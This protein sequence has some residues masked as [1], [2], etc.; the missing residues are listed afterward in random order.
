MNY[1]QAIEDAAFASG[2][3]IIGTR[4][5][6]Q[7][8]VGRDGHKSVER[9]VVLGDTCQQHLCK[10]DRRKFTIRK[11]GRQLGQRLQMQRHQSRTLGTRYSPSE[12]AAAFSW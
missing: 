3:R 8:C 10:L 9:V 5:G 11:T 6:S 7:G 1:G 4:G 12:T 2:E